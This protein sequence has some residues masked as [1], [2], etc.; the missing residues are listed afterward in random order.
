M[1]GA[2][3]VSKNCQQ[4]YKGNPQ[5]C[6]EF[7]KNWGCPPNSPTPEETKRMLQTYAYLWLV[8]LEIPLTSSQS[9]KSPT[10]KE[11]KQFLQ[12]TDHLNAFMA[13]LNENHPDWAIFAS[14][15]C[16]ICEQKGYGRCTCPE[17]PCRFPKELLMSPEATGLD[18]FATLENLDVS[19]EKAPKHFLKRITL[20]ATDEPVNMAELYNQYKMYLEVYQKFVGM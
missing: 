20:F 18:I 2:E 17:T 19:I 16:R 6:P 11:K 3:D 9:K 4:S 14:S 7:G 13:F 1:S 8:V 12:V 15:H 5:G 10:R